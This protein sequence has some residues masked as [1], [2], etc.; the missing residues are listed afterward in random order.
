MSFRT[1][2][3]T[4]ASGHGGLQ[5]FKNATWS[6]ISGAFSSNYFQASSFTMARLG[7]EPTGLKFVLKIYKIVLFAGMFEKPPTTTTTTSMSTS[8][9]TVTLLCV[10]LV[11]FASTCDAQFLQ[12]SARSR[13]QGLSIPTIQVR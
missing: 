10:I 4:L 11:T 2:S 9:S 5:S 3:S 13:D 8:I 12:N 7:F 6:K 1:S